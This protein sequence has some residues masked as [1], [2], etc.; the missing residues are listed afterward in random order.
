MYFAFIYST[1]LSFDFP[2]SF[3]ITRNMKDTLQASQDIKYLEINTLL[4]TIVEDFLF[5]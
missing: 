2:F 4:C 3:I 5:T 1:S